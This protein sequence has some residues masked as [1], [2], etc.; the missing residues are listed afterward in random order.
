MT[1]GR[2]VEGGPGWHIDGETLLPVLH[3]VAAFREA[4]RDDPALEAL[5]ALWSGHPETAE[6]E[7]RRLAD[8]DSPRL[9]ALLADAWRDQ[10]R[11]GEA[12]DAYRELVEEAVGTPREAVL[13]QHAGKALFAAGRHEEALHE[14]ELALSLRVAAGA[15]EPLVASSRAAVERARQVLTPGPPARRG[16]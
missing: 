7:L 10:G 9:R 11:T 5:V 13:R 1:P 14:F 15:E 3:D 6:R 4:H 12:V 16:P 2:R 8:P